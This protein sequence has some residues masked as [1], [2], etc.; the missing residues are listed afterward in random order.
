MIPKKFILLLLVILAVAM[1][2]Y[3]AFLGISILFSYI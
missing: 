1:V 3:A 2:I